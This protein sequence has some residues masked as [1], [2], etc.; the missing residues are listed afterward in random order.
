MPPAASPAHA[1]CVGGRA[2]E[3]RQYG[4]AMLNGWGNHPHPHSMAQ[5]RPAHEAAK[6]GHV[7]CLRVL[8]QLGADLC[9]RDSSERTPAHDA[10]QWGAANCLR[11][12]H[13]LG[14]P[15]TAADDEGK[16]PAYEAAE[17]IKIN[18][19]RALSEVL[20][21]EELNAPATDGTTPLMA[22]C[23]QTEHGRPN[24]QKKCLWLLLNAGA[25]L[26]AM[27][28]NGETALVHACYAGSENCVSVLIKAGADVNGIDRPLSSALM[29]SCIG[30]HDGCVR[31]L[32]EAGVDVNATNRDAYTEESEES[33]EHVVAGAGRTVLMYASYAGADGCVRL[34][35]AAGASLD[36]VVDAEGVDAWHGRS[37]LLLACEKGEAACA[38]AL[39][40]A[41]ADEAAAAA[42]IEDGLPPMTAAQVAAAHSLHPTPS[43]PHSCTPLPLYPTPCTPLPAPHSNPPLAPPIRRTSSLTPLS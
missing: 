36:A 13:E 16:T 17:N 14:V 25:Q 19:L 18:C 24:R 31:L 37:A 29:Y 2:E 39:L 30:G 10:A 33:E 21:A 34:L 23:F 20:S 8:H 38:S 4:L 6:Y 15:L 35:I 40:Q 26:E 42:V 28:E 41:G 22:A 11:T 7:N 32:I 1:A 27:D 5:R 9:A 12:L 3:L 43:A